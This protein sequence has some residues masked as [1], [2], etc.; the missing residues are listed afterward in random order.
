MRHWLVAL[1]LLNTATVAFAQAP[2]LDYSILLGEDDWDAGDSARHIAVDG[3]GQAWVVAAGTR[4]TPAPAEEVQQDYSIYSIVRLSPAG[5]LLSATPFGGSGYDSIHS[6]HLDAA[7]NLYLVGTTWSPDFPMT[8][9]VGPPGPINEAFVVKLDAAGDLVYSTRFRGTPSLPSLSLIDI[10]VDA[11][12]RAH[13]VGNIAGSAYALASDMFI[14]K[15]SADGSSLIYSLQLGGSDADKARGI[16]LDSAGNAHVAGFTHSADFP[17]AQRLPQNGAAGFPEAVVL[18][19]GPDGSRIYST[20]LGGSG[21]DWAQAIAI[22]PAGNALVYGVTASPDFPVRVAL[23]PQAA[24]VPYDWDHPYNEPYDTFLT[25]LDP[26]GALHGSTFLGGTSYDGAIALSVNP[27]GF[28]YLLG[29]TW[30]AEDF[31]LRDPLPVQLYGPWDYPINHVTLLDPQASE[32]LFS[33][34]LDGTDGDEWGYV[35][36]MAVDATGSIYLSGMT[37]DTEF[38]VVGPSQKTQANYWYDAFVVKIDPAL[39]DPPVCTA[40]TASPAVL[41]TPYGWFRTVTVQGVTDPD[42]DRVSAIVTRITQDELPSRSGE[43]DARGVGTT[44]PSVRADRMSSGDG[45]VYHLT[46]TASD[47]EGSTCSGR[48]TVCVPVDP[49]RPAC[50][51]GGARFVSTSAER[52]LP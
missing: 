39:N 1:L 44:R 37:R 52:K 47:P 42:G 4:F 27:A 45:R 24:F 34:F 8:H 6:I 41:G 51:D 36:G 18:K 17:Q 10:A 23:Q 33:T 19:L 46:F 40:A 3:A 2:H 5:A 29:S 12:G 16:A 11:Q 30:S 22:D 32:I 7:G 48:V 21:G 25:R 15:L 31:P 50:R 49:N 14:A 28:I 26:A 20:L 43:P 9:L 35:Y 38:P 13:V